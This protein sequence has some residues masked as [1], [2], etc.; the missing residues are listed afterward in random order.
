[1]KYSNPQVILISKSIIL[2][3]TYIVYPLKLWMALGMV[4]IWF[5][6]LLF[7]TRFHFV[8]S[9]FLLSNSCG[10]EHECFYRHIFKLYP[11][12][13]GKKLI[14]KCVFCSLENP[15]PVI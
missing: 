14:F 5:M 4:S 1:M 7:V 12:C 8:V 3:S 13:V 2:I 11:R 6:V 9:S 15:K 10:K